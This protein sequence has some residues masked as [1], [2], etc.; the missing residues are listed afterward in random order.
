MS[1]FDTARLPPAAQTWL[2]QKAKTVTSGSVDAFL[3]KV[4]CR[5]QEIE[6]EEHATLEKVLEEAIRSDSQEMTNSEWDE[7]EREGLRRIGP[8]GN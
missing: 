8:S 3:S 4:I 2:E 6:I 1:T 5:M 7:I